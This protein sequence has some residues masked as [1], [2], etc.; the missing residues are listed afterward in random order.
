MAGLKVYD[1]FGQGLHV[2][3]GAAPIR[4]TRGSAV[5]H[6]HPQYELLLVWE[7]NIN[8][9]IINGRC[10]TIDHPMAIITSPYVMHHTIFTEAE[11]SSVNRLV[12][13]FDQSFLDAFEACR[14]SVGE[15]L[16]N[17]NA[18]VLDL[19][20][21][22]DW[23]REL[24]DV[25]VRLGTPS[26]GRQ[27][28][29]NEKQIFMAAVLFGALRDLTGPSDGGMRISEKNYIT[30]VM[31]YIALNLSANLTISKIAEQFFISRDKLCRDFR[32]YMQMNIGDFI[33]TA[34]LNLARRYLED[35][36][37]TVKEISNRCGF[38]NDVYFYAFFKKHEGCTPKEFVRRKKEE[39]Q[40]ALT[41]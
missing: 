16:G 19:R 25:F 21:G 14:V 27:Y 2:E 20:M 11:R 28:R 13:Y 40:A 5:F 4:Q 15:L 38:E 8:E 35:G 1:D 18:T 10:F 23:I 31:A 34:R 30:E 6:M 37:L 9:T 33:S 3:Y 24:V 26:K 12:L 41:S 22:A 36:E 39:K 29:A 7:P 17:A 32:R